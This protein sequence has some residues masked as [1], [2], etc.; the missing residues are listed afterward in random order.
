MGFWS[1]FLGEKTV[2]H[3]KLFGLLQGLLLAKHHAV[4]SVVCSLDSLE[5]VNLVVN[6]VCKFHQYATIVA[7]IRDLIGDNWAV[8]I[9]HSLR[10]T[11][12]CPNY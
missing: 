9:E 10:E 5:V 8:S 4:F 3:A 2:L 6:G 12:M 7:G 1:G 11:N